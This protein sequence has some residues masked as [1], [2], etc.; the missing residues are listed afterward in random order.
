MIDVWIVEDNGE[1]R[2][3]YVE[4]INTDEEMICSQQFSNCEDAIEK[5][6]REKTPDVILMD[7]GLPG[8]SGIEGLQQ[9]KQKFPSI[10]IIMQ[11]VFEDNEKIFQAVCAGASGYLLKRSPAEQILNGIKEVRSGGSP[12]N[13]HI[14]RKVMS[15][16]AEIIPPQTNYNLTQREKEILQFLVDGKTIKS[17]SEFLNLSYFTVGTHIKNIYSKLQVNSRSLVVAKALKENLAK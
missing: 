12:I 17:I 2:R 3:S 9:I 10:D 4:L 8:M 6:D 13:A 15:M 11:T 14:A 5:L 16:F 7:I 1:M